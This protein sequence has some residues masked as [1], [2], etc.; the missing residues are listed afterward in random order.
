MEI[1]ATWF[2]LVTKHAFVPIDNK[3]GVETV[4]VPLWET[5]L[6]PKKYFVCNI[7]I[8][9]KF[10]CLSTAYLNAKIETC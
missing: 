3:D 9:E 7:E 4:Y 2:L 1:R 10:G 6:I 5:N 8:E